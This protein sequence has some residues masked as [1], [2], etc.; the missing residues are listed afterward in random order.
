MSKRLLLAVLAIALLAAPAGWAFYREMSAGVDMTKA[1]EA[2]LST[3]TPE[4]RTRAL[5]EFDSPRRVDWHFIPKNDRKG[6]Q[7]KDMNEG[8]R[9]AA[10]ALLRSS[11]SEVG[12]DKATQIMELETLLHFLEKG[13]GQ[14]IRDPYRY[15]FTLFGQPQ[16]DERWGLSVEGHHLSLNFV[17]VKGKVVASTPQVFCTN[18]AEVK[19]DYAGYEGPVKKGTRILAKEELLAFGLVNSFTP[20][21]SKEALIDATAPK[22]IRAAGEL[23]PPKTDPV[24]LPASKLKPEQAKALKTLIDEY[25]AAMPYEVRGERQTAIETAGYEKIHFAWAG[26]T[27]PGIGHY[28]RV[29][30]PTFLIEFVNTQPDAAGNPA[31]HIHCVWR[32]MAGDFAIA[33]K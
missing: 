16:G 33:I 24:G 8:Q 17:V 25:I 22:E 26:A 6:V 19:A 1:A 29:Q 5:L 4:Q 12:Y 7:I 11:L 14:N 31:N 27:K 15:Y 28:Y 23:H 10:H 9:K 21:Q 2:F 13:M 32:D 30:G 18:P 3:L 20:E